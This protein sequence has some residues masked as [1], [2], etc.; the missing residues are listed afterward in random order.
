M[1]SSNGKRRTWGVP[2]GWMPEKMVFGGRDEV[3]LKRNRRVLRSTLLCFIQERR[4]L[5]EELEFIAKSTTDG[6]R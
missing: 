6:R 3:E 4:K 5:D 2:V 1:R